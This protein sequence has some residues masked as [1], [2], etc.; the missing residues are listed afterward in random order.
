LILGIVTSLTIKSI[1]A[2]KLI[3][4]SGLMFDISGVIRLFLDDEWK[5]IV[6]LFSDTQEY[7][8]GPPSYVTRELFADENVEVSGEEEQGS[9]KRHYY[10][11]RGFILIMIGFIL[12][13]IGIVIA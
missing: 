8:Y 7:P 4:I 6:S 13:L 12:Q 10:N 5:D 3:T 2:G 9:I 1:L 11:K